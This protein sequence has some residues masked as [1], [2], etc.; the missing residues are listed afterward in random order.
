MGG[1]RLKFPR[2]KKYIPS[3][4]KQDKVAEEESIS[5]EEHKKRIEYLKNLGLIKE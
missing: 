5:E 2:R 3:K 4:L 1:K